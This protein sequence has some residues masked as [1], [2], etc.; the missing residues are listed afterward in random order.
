MKNDRSVGSWKLDSY[1]LHI[2]I[3]FQEIKKKKVPVLIN[4]SLSTVTPQEVCLR[5]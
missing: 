1:Y 4:I 2:K 5:R 3:N